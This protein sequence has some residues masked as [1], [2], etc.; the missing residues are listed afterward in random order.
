M[1]AKMFMKANKC[2]ADR[3]RMSTPTIIRGFLLNASGFFCRFSAEDTSV[4]LSMHGFHDFQVDFLRR[5]RLNRQRIT[6]RI[7]K[8]LIHPDLEKNYGNCA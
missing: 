3:I 4:L 7:Y 6:N 2:S 8:P 5:K 1:T